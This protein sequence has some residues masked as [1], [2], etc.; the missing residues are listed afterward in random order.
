MLQTVL[1]LFA[2]LNGGI[3]IG[4]SRQHNGHTFLG[5]KGE[6]GKLDVT[7][8]CWAPCSLW[9]AFA[10][11]HVS[12]VQ[13]TVLLKI[14]LLYILYIIQVYIAGESESACVTSVHAESSLGSVSEGQE[15]RKELW[16]SYP[17]LPEI[18]AIGPM[19]RC[20]KV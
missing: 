17:L 2:I 9:L 6:R 4:I 18:P 13:F 15:C 5:S 19:L 16:A 14:F 11:D 3:S 20:L 1:S 8:S 10:L 12:F 7:I